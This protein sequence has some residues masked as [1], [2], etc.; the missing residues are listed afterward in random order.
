MI[1]PRAV[2]RLRH[3]ALACGAPLLIVACHKAADDESDSTAAVVGAQTIVVEPQ[4]FTETI[5]AIGDVE[6]RVGHVARLSAPV[7]ARIANVLV[8]AGQH[9]AQGQPL[10]EL[11]QTP[12]R[13]ATQ[14]AQA[15]LS[16]AE[17]ANERSQRL[18]AEG[19][20]A[21]KDADQTA[22]DLA[23]ARADAANAER[24]EAL[25]VLRAPISGVITQMSATLGASAD[26]SQTLIEIADPSAVD[27][28]FNVTPTDAARVHPGAKV[29][30][31]AGQSATG[32][33]LGIGSVVDVSGTVDS[34]TR[35]VAVRVRAPTT[36]RPLRLGE[37]VFGAIAVETNPSA[38]VVPLEALVP[39]GEAF[40]VFVVDP[41][42]TAHEREVSVGGKTNSVAEITSGLR[43]GERVVTYGAY[44]VDDSA[45]IAPMTPVPAARGTARP[46]AAGKP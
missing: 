18:A 22:A 46:P 14:S 31:S 37:T 36:R 45:K 26:P 42:G 25:S 8:A 20:L 23:R 2:Y 21:R 27:I 11:D 29:T 17:R 5:G 34:A 32:E 30:L 9:V 3:L 15:A 28:V 12:F 1:R 41:T 43:A 24:E 10:V 7:A 33:A 6:P 44:G 4:P 19:I 35:S 16:A 40:H 39:E 13:A 38:I